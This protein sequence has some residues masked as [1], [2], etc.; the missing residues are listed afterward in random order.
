MQPVLQLGRYFFLRRSVGRNRRST[1]TTLDEVPSFIQVSLPVIEEML[2]DEEA[3]F[4]LKR[5]FWSLKSSY[6]PVIYSGGASKVTPLKVTLS[7]FLSISL[8][9]P[10]KHSKGKHDQFSKTVNQVF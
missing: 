4:D 10:S 8:M 3:K 1:N 5:L 7:A 9:R 2:A 6:S